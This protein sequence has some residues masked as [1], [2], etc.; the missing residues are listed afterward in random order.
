MAGIE[1]TLGGDFSVLNKLKKDAASAAE[2]VKNSFA[3]DIGGK[4][5]AGLGIAAGAA[6]A[7]IVVSV[8][9]AID[10]GG[11]LNDMMARTGAGGEGLVIL[12][13]AFKNVGM[14]AEQVPAAL[15][16]MQKALAGSNEEGEETNSTFERLRLSA[17]KLSNLDAVDAFREIGTAIAAISDPA[18]R[19]SATMAIFGKSASELL[20]LMTDAS[21]FSGAEEMVGGMAKMLAENASKLDSAGDSL[22]SLETK[23]TQLGLGLAVELL[24]ALDAVAKSINA[25]D[26]TAVGTAIGGMVT[27]TA[28]F[29]GY[30][31]KL[32]DNNPF[33]K[34]IEQAGYYKTMMSDTGSTTMPAV[35]E[36]VKKAVVDVAIEGPVEAKKTSAEIALEK[37]KETKEKELQILREAAATTYNLESE[38]LS[39]RLRGDEQKIAS[40]QREAA[41][42]AEMA[43]LEKAGFSEREART[44]ATAAVDAEATASL[45][46]RQRDEAQRAT[47]EQSQQARSERLSLQNEVQNRLERTQS[48]IAGQSFDSTIGAMGSMQRIGGGGGAVSSGL[49]YA[50][51]SADLQKEANA[52]LKQIVELSRT[53]DY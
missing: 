22:G 15:A 48:D 10:A 7:G 39:A 11:N 8:K 18:E 2:S 38:M 23:V 16:K 42:R 47:D 21:A 53:V 9:K 25:S 35:V 45:R 19:A 6:M 31:L 12:Q 51:K 3:K 17:A 29:T 14:S 28:S 4:V 27:A 13:Q 37:T 5:F 34:L 33:Y 50:R 20:A 46:E 44:P 26:L 36:Q 32:A 41:I 24:P 52:Y 30:M 49:D 43:K 40:L 1:I